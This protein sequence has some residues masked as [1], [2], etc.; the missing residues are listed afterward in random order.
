MSFGPADFSAGVGVG[1][2]SRLSGGGGSATWAKRTPPK[3]MAPIVSSANPPLRC[4]APELQDDRPE[5]IERHRCD[6]TGGIVDLEGRGHFPSP[7]GTLERRPQVLEAVDR[8][9]LGVR[10][11]ITRSEERRVGKECRSRW[12]PYH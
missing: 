6:W 7:V 4:G 1:V 5:L 11:V 3:R 12:S 8:D 2:G 9:R 10:P